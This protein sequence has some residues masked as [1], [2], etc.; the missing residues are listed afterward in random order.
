MQCEQSW[1]VNIN[2]R[3]NDAG[4]TNRRHMRSLITKYTVINR[5]REKDDEKC[6]KAE[7]PC[8]SMRNDLIPWV[9]QVYHRSGV[10]RI[11]YRADKDAAL[12]AD[13]SWNGRKAYLDNE[14]KFNEVSNCLY[15][16]RYSQAN[17]LCVFEQIVLFRGLSPRFFTIDSYH[18][19][20]RVLRVRRLVITNIA[21]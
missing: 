3:S 1:Q 9:S 7:T 17:I 21:Y 15:K 11:L 4:A 18:C 8:A 5:G 6:R 13:K 10:S 16:T 19:D 20:A 12:N 14:F 2:V